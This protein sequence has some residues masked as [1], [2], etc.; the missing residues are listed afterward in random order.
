MCRVVDVKPS[1]CL[2]CNLQTPS[3]CEIRVNGGR[4][5]PVLDVLSSPGL[6]ARNGIPLTASCYHP[7]G[8]SEPNGNGRSPPSPRYVAAHTW[9]LTS[10][11]NLEAQTT[12]WVSTSN[13]AVYIIAKTSRKE[14]AVVLMLFSCARS[15]SAEKHPV[16]TASLMPRSIPKG[17]ID[18]HSDKTLTRHA[19]Y[20]HRRISPIYI[21]Q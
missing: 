2:A 14:R 4:K 10:A 5:H 18:L 1:A 19:G 9:K 16:V 12:S 11:A 8:H 17:R 21:R 7:P 3:R 6:P 13:S 15:R 20:S